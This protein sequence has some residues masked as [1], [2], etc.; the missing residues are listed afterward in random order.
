MFEDTTINPENLF[1]VTTN[2]ICDRVANNVYF[3]HARLPPFFKR[4]LKVFKLPQHD[5]FLLHGIWPL[6]K[7]KKNPQALFSS[8]VMVADLSR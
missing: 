3:G 7:K 6:G 1:A 2:I 4:K 5:G 8:L